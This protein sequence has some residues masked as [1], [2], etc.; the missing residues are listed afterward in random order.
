MSF[1]QD[2]VPDKCQG[3][4]FLL[5]VIA[6]IIA[7][8]HWPHANQL[9]EPC[10]MLNYFFKFEKILISSY[11]SVPRM[12]TTLDKYMV[13]VLQFF[14]TSNFLT[15]LIIIAIQLQNPCAVPFIGS[16]SHYCVNALWSPPLILV[17]AAMLLTDYWIWLHISYDGIFFMTYAFT[18]SMVTLIDYLA[19]FKKLVR[20][21]RTVPP[22]DQSIY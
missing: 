20:E 2:S 8:W 17:R 21:I 7:R 1:G 18:V 3:V 4:V 12:P 9:N 13:V 6:C 22:N 10:R 16:M 15:P 11:G 14:E 5:L 19:H